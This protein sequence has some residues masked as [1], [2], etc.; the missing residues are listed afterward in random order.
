MKKTAFYPVVAVFLLASIWFGLKSS[1]SA[2]DE[3]LTLTPSTVKPVIK[4]GATATG[5]FQIINQG[6]GDYPLHVYAAPYSVHNEA[7]T[8]DFSPV[9]GQP[10][11]ASWLHFSTAESTVQPGQTLTVNYTLAVP[12]GT[13]PGGYY[14]VAFAQT[15]TSQAKQGVVVNERVGEIFYIQV[16]G[17]VKQ[18]GKVLSWASPFLQKPPL[19]ANLRLENDGGLDYS[20]NL[21]LVVR[22]LFG[23]AKYT[24]NTQKEVLPRTIRRIPDVWTKTPSLGLFKV[25]GTATILG[26]TH[27]LPTKYVLVVS[28]T[29]RKVFLVIIIVLIALGV[30]RFIMRRR[31]KKHGTKRSRSAKK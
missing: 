31:A 5:S 4:P 26:K 2:A 21:H 28:Q 11:V 10:D 19:T 6:Q 27:K 1:A 7:Y 17:P 3:T 16:A 24:L 22:D 12:T 13:A 25:N 15:Q 9:P 18:S 30:G 14:A 23:H 8:P 20:S 29:I